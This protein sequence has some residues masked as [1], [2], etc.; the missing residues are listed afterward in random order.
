MG[1]G[2]RGGVGAHESGWKWP[3]V[4]ES[5]QPSWEAAE[6]RG[7]GREERKWLV[8]GKGEVA[9]GPGEV[10]AG[11]HSTAVPVTLGS[12]LSWRLSRVLGISQGGP[13]MN[14]DRGVFLACVGLWSQLIRRV[15]IPPCVQGSSALE[16]VVF[17]RLLCKSMSFRGRTWILVLTLTLIS[18]AT[19]Y[20]QRFQNPGL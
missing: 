13:W 15:T 2:L 9:E 14:R 12:H 11:P 7:R 1:A 4:W 10:G 18:C 19:N 17:L 20:G 5:P 3:E 8:G 16:G 6:H